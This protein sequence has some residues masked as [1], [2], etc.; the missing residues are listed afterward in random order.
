MQGR[1]IANFRDVVVHFRL[2]CGP[3]G[4]LNGAAYAAWDATESVSPQE[5]PMPEPIVP[6]PSI[7]IVFMSFR[8]IFTNITV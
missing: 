5:M 7:P 4:D 8:S 6:P 1:L 2:F 3:A